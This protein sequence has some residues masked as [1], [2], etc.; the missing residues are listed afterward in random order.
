M[1]KRDELPHMAEKL[2]R[3][4]ARPGMQ[5]VARKTNG[6]Q[7]V[8]HAID[9]KQWDAAVKLLGAEKISALAN[10]A[11]GIEEKEVISA[12]VKSGKWESA[13]RKAYDWKP[14]AVKTRQPR[15]APTLEM[16]VG[17]D[18]KLT[19]AELLDAARAAGIEVNIQK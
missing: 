13:Q 12:E 5:W 7:Y 1:A 9:P 3:P 10:R 16:K 18:G 4:A 15:K 8:G 2:T 14:E 19:L 6:R 17:K 11:L